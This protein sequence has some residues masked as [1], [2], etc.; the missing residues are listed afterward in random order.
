M[1]YLKLDTN[2]ELDSKTTKELLSK[3]SAKLSSVLG[4]PES[5]VLVHINSGQTMMFAGS[6]DPL[7]YLEL[8]SIGLLYD[9]APS[10]SAL[11]CEFIAEELNIPANRVYIEFTDIPREMWGWDSRTFA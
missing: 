4:K 6:T 2:L 3:S 9:Q 11:F 10:L 7:A 5:Y 1:P 8:K